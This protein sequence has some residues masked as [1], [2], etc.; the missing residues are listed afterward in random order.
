M[1]FDDSIIQ[2]K[3]HKQHL[4]ENVHFLHV[5]RSA[6]VRGGNDVLKRRVVLKEL[7]SILSKVFMII[8]LERKNTEQYF[9]VACVLD[10]NRGKEEGVVI[11][12]A[13]DI[14]QYI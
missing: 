5:E 14:F 10:K 11:A 7:L 3:D 8:N 13:E 1:L 6:G 2:N 9:I 12:L 4:L